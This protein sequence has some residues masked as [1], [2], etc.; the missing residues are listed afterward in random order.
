MHSTLVLV[1]ESLLF[2][3]HTKSLIKNIS[4]RNCHPSAVVAHRSQGLGAH[5]FRLCPQEIPAIHMQ[6][7]G[8]A[9]KVYN[10]LGI[11]IRTKVR[12]LGSV[13][14]RV[15]DL[16]WSSQLQKTMVRRP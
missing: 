16:L 14:V 9:I 6:I 10:P 15:R 13:R 11:E 8:E 2:Q 5:P 7:D 3:Y 4:S 12:A 1:G